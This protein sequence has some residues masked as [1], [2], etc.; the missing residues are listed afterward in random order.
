VPCGIAEF[1]V[2]SL[3]EMGVS[4]GQE[5]FD[6]ALSQGLG[7]FLASLTGPE[8]VEGASLSVNVSN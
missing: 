3:D 5:R 1:P 4:C 6:L 2:T 8:E 7:L